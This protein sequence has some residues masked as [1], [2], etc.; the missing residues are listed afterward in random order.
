MGTNTDLRPDKPRTQV[1]KPCL[2][3]AARPPLSQRNRA[4][5]VEADDIDLPMS[6]PIVAIGKFDLLDIVVLI[7]LVRSKHQ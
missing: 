5:P 3:L 1:R 6:L 7:C 4:V 2:D